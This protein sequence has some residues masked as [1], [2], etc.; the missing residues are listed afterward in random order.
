[1]Q[2]DTREN[3]PGSGRDTLNHHHHAAVP[4]SV[5]PLGRNGYA[6]LAASR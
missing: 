6:T 2:G 5:Y 3:P 1:M 4:D